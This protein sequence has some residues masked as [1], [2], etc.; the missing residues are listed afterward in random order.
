MR[1]GLGF[2]L[3]LLLAACAGPPAPIPDKLSLDA[4]DFAELPG[5]SA[6]DPSLTLQAFLKSC[7]RLALRRQD[8]PISPT[9]LGGRAAD[10]QAP[11]ADARVPKAGDADAARAFFERNFQAF[12]LGNNGNSEAFVTGYYEPELA[13]STMRSERYRVPLYRVP[14]DLV[15]VDLG[16]FRDGW[17]GERIAGRVI[18]GRLKPYFTRADID[19]GAL[20]GRDLEL[21]WVDD[22]ID[23]FFLS[24]QGSGRIDLGQGASTRLAFAGQ[25]GQRYVAI[26]RTLVERGALPKDGVS[27][28]SI[29]AWLKANPND[30]PAVMATNPSYVFFRALAGDGPIGAEGAVLTA[31]RS[32]AVDPAFL[33]LGAPIYVDLGEPDGGGR[34]SRLLVAQDT[35]GAI[36]GPVR[37]DFF[38]GTG[39]D[40]G[41]RAG[42]MQAH[43]RFYLLLPRSLPAS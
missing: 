6:D 40:A 11:C 9:G 28:Q 41:E 20:A 42:R 30:A 8:Q 10:W 23:A 34:L 5:W 13:G 31:G 43:G 27:M 15:Q 25:N 7:E 22:A 3:A 2:G 19:R 14:G 24:I 4:V 35:G 33:P 17:R 38:W 12:R 21:I 29:R 18:D 39:A 36:R 16:E 26:G 1:R 32:I 37:G